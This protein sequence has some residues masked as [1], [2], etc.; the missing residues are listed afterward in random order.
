MSKE[1]ED[2]IEAF[3]GS[4]ESEGRDPRP[5]ELMYILRS[6]SAYE[7]G[8]EALARNDLKLARG[9]GHKRARGRAHVPA[10]TVQNWSAADLR[11]RW[12]ERKTPFKRT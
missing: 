2:D 7:S 1:T 4:L 3:I 11:K 8:F 9:R 12:R 5:S 10:G 6:I